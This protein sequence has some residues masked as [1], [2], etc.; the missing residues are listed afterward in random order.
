MYGLNLFDY[1]ARHYDAALG[2]WMVVD[3]LAVNKV[4][5]TPYHY[6]SNNPVNMIDPS[7]MADYYSRLTGKYLGTDYNLKT[8]D[9]MRL[10]DEDSYKGLSGKK[11]PSP[12]KMEATSQLITIDDTKIQTDL[13]AVADLSSTPDENGNYQEHQ[14]YLTL[15]R[16]TA[17]IS[18][19]VGEP[20]S[21]DKVTLSYIPAPVTGVNFVDK[22]GGRVLIGQAH[23]H[24]P[25]TT[26]RMRTEKTMSKNFDMP[27]SASANIPIYGMDAMDG[28]TKGG[29]TSI[30]RVT[31][32]GRITNNVGKTSSGFNI[33]KDAMKIWGIRH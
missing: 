11:I 19:L 25:T 4:W 7:G 3:P 18:S 33:G 10:I 23:G 5:I 9:D 20:G 30:H 15:D 21:A 1:G 12:S 22:P 28:P 31:P 8:S 13:Q 29:P 17:T 2:R 27:T 26:A 6:C 32:D 24:P 16:E 14:I